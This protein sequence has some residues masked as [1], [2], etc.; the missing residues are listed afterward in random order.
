VA[1]LGVLGEEGAVE[2]KRRRGWDWL[3]S[4]ELLGVLKEVFEVLKIEG[5][6]GGGVAEGLREG[7]ERGEA[8]LE[9][10]GGRHLS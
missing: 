1:L 9:R 7:A 4:V 3:R 5:G 8:S 2:G 10:V 6:F